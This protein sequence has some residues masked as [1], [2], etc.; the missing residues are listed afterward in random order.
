MRFG[1][2]FLAFL[3]AASIGFYSDA[4]RAGHDKP[5]VALDN[6]TYARL[7]HEHWQEVVIIEVV[8]P[9]P[10]NSPK[11]DAPSSMR[12]NDADVQPND[13]AQKFIKPYL[14][15]LWFDRR[16][17]GMRHTQRGTGFVCGNDNEKNK[18]LICTNAHIISG[19]IEIIV[20][21]ASGKEYRAA[22]LAENKERDAAVLAI[23][24]HE[25][26]RSVRW[27]DSDAVAV[28]EVI[29]AIGHPHDFR[30]SIHHGIVS[31]KR[32]IRETN[33]A[34]ALPFIQMD[35]ALNSGNSGS[36]LFNMRG[37][38][39]GVVESVLEDSQN[40]AFAIP[41]NDFQKAVATA[42]PPSAMPH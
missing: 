8:V 17:M 26:L 39:V 3:I 27:G 31:G 5:P 18:A 37:E 36:P 23:E 6:L 4:T 33:G 22:V 19:G 11:T 28:G 2:F 15:S 41:A 25:G 10:N 32:K 13:T 16:V 42:L 35:I 24:N 12:Q 38:V 21:T 29:M 1:R 20:R 7:A 34:A 40:I 30:H 14:L 9:A